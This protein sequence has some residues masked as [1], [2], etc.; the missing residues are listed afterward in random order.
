MMEISFFVPGKAQPG[1]SKRAFIIKGRA[2]VTDANKNVA[3]WKHQVKHTA[4]LTYQGPLLSTPLHVVCTFYMQRPSSHYR[5]GKNAHLVK[6]G[7]PGLPIS[8]PDTTKLFRS[9]EDALTGV[10]WVDDAQIVKQD[11]MKIYGDTPG[12]K[13]TIRELR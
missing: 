2:I 12:A 6:D 13:I 10:I 5:T 11:I 4:R 9:T 7:A 3:T 8:K 1:G